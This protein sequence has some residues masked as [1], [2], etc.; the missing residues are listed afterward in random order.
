MG[1]GVLGGL[2]FTYAGPQIVVLL[3]GQKFEAL[4]LLMPWFGL[5]YFVR[6]WAA[7]WGNALTVDGKQH[8]RAIMTAIHWLVI[9]LFSVYLVPV[10]GSVGWILALIIG[11]LFLAVAYAYVLARSIKCYIKNVVVA[12]FAFAFIGIRLKFQ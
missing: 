10:L 9:C 6:M 7:C 5:L 4:K 12:I 8:M 1:I 2:V 11:T 3:F